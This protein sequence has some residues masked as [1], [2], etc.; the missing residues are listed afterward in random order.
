MAS[1]GF[2]FR[3]RG[4]IR[5]ISGSHHAFSM[6][7]PPLAPV[8]ALSPGRSFYAGST[9]NRDGVVKSGEPASRLSRRNEAVRQSPVFPAPKRRRLPVWGWKRLLE[10]RRVRLCAANAATPR[11]P[12]PA[13]ERRQT[14]AYC[15]RRRRAIANPTRAPHPQLN[16]HGAKTPH[17]RSHQHPSEIA[18]EPP[19]TDFFRSLL[20]GQAGL[21]DA[22][23][24]STRN[25]AS[26]R[27]SMLRSEEQRS[28]T[29]SE[30]APGRY[31]RRHSMGWRCS[32]WRGAGRRR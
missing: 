16:R 27:A 15:S 13:R 29:V 25:R 19:S 5:L 22:A 3:N 32:K 17:R 1:R 8:V 9:L 11:S 20:G 14:A 4:H 26:W 2:F 10:Q 30:C 21:W 31:G 23:A 7:C 28:V 6:D 18:A 24:F 12:P